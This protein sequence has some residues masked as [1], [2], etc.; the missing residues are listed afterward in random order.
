V[1]LPRIDERPTELADR[2]AGA[3]LGG[4]E[5]I[6]VLEDEERVRSVISRM[7][8]EAGY[9]LLIAHNAADAIALASTHADR[10]RLVLSDVVM[11][12]ASGPD[13]VQQIQE[14]VPGVRALYMSGYTDHAVLRDGTLQ[15]GVNFIQK[16]FA[17]AALAKKIRSVL[18]RP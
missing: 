18:D 16:P 13:V 7:L 14:R 15:S 4:S 8:Q 5:T 17:P 9:E 1:Y 11:P 6:L 3:P 2:N 12:G 10:L